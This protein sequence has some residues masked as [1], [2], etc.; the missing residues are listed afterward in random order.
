M[1]DRI[2]P[3]VRDGKSE[4]RHSH[5]TR[6]E[7]DKAAEI[8][9]GSVF[10]HANERRTKKAAEVADRID[11]RDAAGRR[12]SL[13]ELSTQGPERRERGVDSGKRQRQSRDGEDWMFRRGGDNETDG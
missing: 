13:E 1:S 6:S 5:I 11:Q 8:A 3:R 10:D 12:R 2:F 4:D 9:A 7:K